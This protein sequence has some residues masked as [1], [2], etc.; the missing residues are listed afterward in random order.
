VEEVELCDESGRK[1]GHFLSDDLYRRVIYD[2]ANAQISDDD[3][4]RADALSPR[5]WRGLGNREV[6][7]PN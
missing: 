3:A 6:R 4:N 7:W 5:S 1:I 2:W